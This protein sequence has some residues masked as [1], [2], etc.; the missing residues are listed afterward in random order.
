MSRVNVGIVGLGIMG[1]MYADFL[2][3]S[4]LAEVRAIAD[5]KADRREF[6]CQTY[7]CQA[8]EGYQ[9]MYDAGGLD[10]VLIIVPDFMHRDPVVQAAQAGLHILV[11]K[12]FAMSVSDANAMVEAI[13]KSG[14]K[15]MVEFFN[16]WSSPFTEAKHLVER[17]DLGDIVAFNIELNDAIWVPTEMLAWSARSSPA[18]F[19]MSHT[20]DLASW[21]TGKKPTAVYAQG[22]KQLLAKR[23]I[24]TYDLIEALVEYPDGTLGRFTNNWVLPDGMPILYELRMRIVGSKA[25]IDIDTSDQ[26][27]HLISQERLTHPVTAWGDILGRYVGHPYTM[28]AAFLDNIIEDTEPLVGAINGWENTAFLE[29]VHRS[30]VTGQKVTIGR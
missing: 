4:P 9:E 8:Y 10:V 18:W 17:G 19:L 11:E 25:A 22:V 13:D 1:Q 6:A 23:G 26:E 2:M 7:G 21:I 27:I 30:V 16:R 29:A 3:R 12:P 14:V 15:C 20:A 24:D 28:L 5:P